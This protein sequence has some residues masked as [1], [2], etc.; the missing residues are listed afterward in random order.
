MEQ[1]GERYTTRQKLAATA[2]GIF[3]ALVIAIVAASIAIEY[4]VQSNFAVGM[5]AQS[6]IPLIFVFWKWPS[7]VLRP[8]ELVRKLFRGN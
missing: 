8:I 1:Q 6:T 3:A 5:A 7:L 4:G 2:I